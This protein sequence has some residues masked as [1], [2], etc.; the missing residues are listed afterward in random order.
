M[1]VFQTFLWELSDEN[2]NFVIK[3]RF[4][5]H[6][7]ISNVFFSF[8]SKC[9]P[10]NFFQNFLNKKLHSFLSKSSKVESG[11]KIAIGLIRGF[12]HKAAFYLE[13]VEK[14]VR[15]RILKKTQKIRLKWENKDG[16][17]Y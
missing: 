13:N 7:P 14:N 12:L 8:L 1:R 10:L 15:G 5:S 11:A 4:H 16:Y 6:F 9:D 17:F 3:R 2:N